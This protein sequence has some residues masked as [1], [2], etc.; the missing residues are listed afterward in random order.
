MHN[1]LDMHC[2]V[3]LCSYVI[4]MLLIRYD[5]DVLVEIEQE[6]QTIRVRL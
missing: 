2:E 5:V 6:M 4:M 1:R 3:I